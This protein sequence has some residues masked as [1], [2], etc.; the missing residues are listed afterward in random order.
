MVGVEPR[1]YVV[2]NAIVVCVGIPEVIADR[3]GIEYPAGA[4]LAAVCG[5]AVLIELTTVEFPA[6]TDWNEAMAEPVEVAATD[7]DGVCA[8]TPDEVARREMTRRAIVDMLKECV[9]WIW[10]GKSG[11]YGAMEGCMIECVRSSGL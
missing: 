5:S 9:V 11:C 6:A 3:S 4:P 8:E 1:A 10:L 7:A 2:S